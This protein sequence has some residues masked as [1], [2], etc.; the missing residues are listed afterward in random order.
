VAFA[1]DG[2]MRVVD[3]GRIDEWADV[4][5]KQIE[6][7]VPD[8][9]EAAPGPWVIVDAG[10]D[11][12]E[13]YDVCAR[14]KWYASLGSGQEEFVHPPHSPFAGTRQLFSEPRPID[15]GFGTTTQGRTYA[16]YFLWASQRI[17]DLQAQL[18]N[19]GMME[20]AKDVNGWCPELATHVNSHRQAMV[21]DKWG[22]EKREWKRI[23]DTPDHLYDCLS[24]AVVAGCMAGIYRKET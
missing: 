22:K 16:M 12:I 17:Q 21:I 23:G 18:R 9:T 13:V 11:P 2:R 4:R 14:Y 19:G 7:G 10:H 6:L 15:V 8:P 20:F 5:K 1:K 24:T 3:A